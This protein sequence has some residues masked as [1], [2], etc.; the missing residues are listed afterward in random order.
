MW[1]RSGV[2]CDGFRGQIAEVRV[3]S[4]CRSLAAI[5]ASLS[6]RLR[7]WE[8][9]L[10]GYWPLM[11]MDKLAVDVSPCGN[12][13]LLQG[14]FS[15]SVSSGWTPSFKARGGGGGSLS[16]TLLPPVFGA[17]H[18]AV[19]PMPVPQSTTSGAAG[20]GAADAASTGFDEQEGE[21]VTAVGFAGTAMLS[22]F[23][24]RLWQQRSGDPT[25]AAWLHDRVSVADG[26]EVRAE[27]LALTPGSHLTVVLRDCT[28]WGLSPLDGCPHPIPSSAAT[29]DASSSVLM[30]PRT[31]AI[32]FSRLRIDRGVFEL[33]VF[34]RGA[35]GPA[36]CLGRR[37][38]DCTEV[39]GRDSNSAHG[40]VCGCR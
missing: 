23:R 12:H 30:P 21:H 14:P 20:A 9:D 5:R 2:V 33:R 27:V 17:V 25:G 31:L 40:G 8:T 34:S 24:V 22:G 1:C 3:W 7:G 4:C 18:S 32:Q 11:E 15:R 10:C 35:F 13:G 38:D 6:Q 16:D 26:F 19:V 37:R 36:V 39:A 28:R 29:S